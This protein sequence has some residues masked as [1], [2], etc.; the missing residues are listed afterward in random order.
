MLDR[1]RKAEAEAA[2][3]KSQLKSETSTS[4]RTLR[5]MEAQV[6]Q[7]TAVSQKCER[8]YVTL[9]DAIT[10]LSEGW[11][12]DVGQLKKE[13]QEREAKVRTEAEDIGRKYKRLLEQSEK[14]REAY[15]SVKKILEEE[16]RLQQDLK[17]FFGSQLDELHGSLQRSEQDSS[18]AAKM[19]Q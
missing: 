13:M 18:S 8:E 12:H 17:D 19:A 5:E 2:A 6:Q 11:K 9:R 10:H 15:A 1:A 3:L 7:S 4:K 16:R 14:E